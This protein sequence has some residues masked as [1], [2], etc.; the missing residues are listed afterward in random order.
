MGI[1]TLTEPSPAVSAGLGRAAMTYWM[2]ATLS[3]WT[4][5]SASTARHRCPMV[6]MPG[7]RG[8]GWLRANLS[9]FG[10]RSPTFTSSAPRR[11]VRIALSDRRRLGGLTQFPRRSMLRATVNC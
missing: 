2:L 11:T 7:G 4:R 5:P 3:C 6:P 10:T 9:R 1:D 8:V